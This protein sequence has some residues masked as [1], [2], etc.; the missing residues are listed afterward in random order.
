MKWVC[1]NGFKSFI[2]LGKWVV[3][4][5]SRTTSHK[6]PQFYGMN[7]NTYVGQKKGQNAYLVAIGHDHR[8]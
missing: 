3:D 8:R 4:S 6:V 7:G 2:I 1:V 5:V